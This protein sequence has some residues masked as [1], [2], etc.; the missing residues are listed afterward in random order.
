M[1]IKS[2]EIRKG[3]TGTVRGY[4]NVVWDGTY[5]FHVDGAAI[6][7]DALDNFKSPNLPLTGSLS[8]TAQGAGSLRLA[9]S[10][11]SR[12]RSRTSS[13]A[14]RASGRSRAA[15]QWPTTS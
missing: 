12:D 4:A 8:F 14:T 7:I 13:S 10:T 15:W 6:P 1:S 9:R 5:G 11:R 2:L 3:E